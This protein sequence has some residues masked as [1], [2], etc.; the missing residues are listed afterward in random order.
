MS[1]INQI[2]SDKKFPAFITSHS[3]FQA[4][5]EVRKVFPE[6]GLPNSEAEIEVDNKKEARDAANNLVSE[7][8]YLVD[9]RITTLHNYCSKKS[10]TIGPKRKKKLENVNKLLGAVKTTLTRS[11][12]KCLKLQ[13]GKITLNLPQNILDIE[14]K[15]IFK[16]GE[17]LFRIYN[18]LNDILRDGHF[19]PMEKYE[20][21]EEFKEFSSK[22]VPALKYKVRFSSDGSDGMWDIATMSMRGIT[23]CQ[24]WDSVNSSHIIGSVVDPFT[25]IIY[26][27]SGAKYNDLGDKMIRRCVVRFMVDE[28]KKIPFIGLEK[29]YPS[30]EKGAL[31]AFIGFLKTR[32]DNKFNVVYLPEMR[33]TSVYIPMSKVV[34]ELKQPNYPYRDSEVE[35][36]TDISSKDSIR[37]QVREK[38]ETIGINVAAKTIT[39]ARSMRLTDIPVGSKSTFKVLRGTDYYSDHSFYLIRC[40]QAE[41]KKFFDNIS[42]DKYTNKAAFLKSAIELLLAD[43]LEDRLFDAINSV[44]SMY[45]YGSSYSKIDDV[46]IRK[47]AKLSCEKI[48]AYLL[49]ELKKIRVVETKTPEVNHPATAIYMKLLG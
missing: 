16:S 44:L 49:T 38:L 19:L 6:I 30:M 17:G 10:D 14:D 32:T 29:M 45:I 24:S 15:I 1:N 48:S 5:K 20:S 37:E 33:K 34:K 46:V 43:K 9:E 8:K 13:R 22:N 26:L 7:I 25:A 2:F 18:K 47:L 27:T 21:L 4:F 36:K 11:K 3:I 40:I 12:S 28:K 31:N 42:M 35:Y 39:A 41:V 23:S